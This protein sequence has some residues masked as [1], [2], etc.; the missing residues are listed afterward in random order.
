V[1]TT[2]IT[3]GT[4]RGYR[5]RTT[6]AALAI[7]LML[8][9]AAVQPARASATFTV[10][11]TNDDGAGSLR[12][13]MLDANANAGADTIRFDIPGDGV[14]TISPVSALPA[15]TDTVT[16]DGYTQPGSS[17]NTLD[18]SQG[19]TNAK[20]LIELNGKNA[21]SLANGLTIAAP[22]TV[23]KGLVINNFGK[24][25]IS[26][27]VNGS[28]VTLDGSDSRVEGNFIGTDATGTLERGN[29]SDGADTAG[30]G[31]ITV[32]SN[33]SKAARNLISG[34]DESGVRLDGRG[35]SRGGDDKV[36]GN[37]IGTKK[38]GK[39][40]LPNLLELRHTR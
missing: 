12:Q 7:G 40:G 10:T 30:I 25:G 28:D 22:S 14:Q 33:L 17:P 38:D 6:L 32:G 26:F 21:G 1:T 11:N 9:P 3:T 35:F 36:L 39:S 18:L 27:H 34:N 8:I 2:Q 4:N 15:V 16:I 29:G 13:A 37:L 31:R 19:A 23:V 20:P 24:D 5:V